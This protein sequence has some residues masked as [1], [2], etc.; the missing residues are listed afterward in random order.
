MNPARKAFNSWKERNGGGTVEDFA[1][2][3]GYSP[4][5]I[6]RL[7][8]GERP[9]PYGRAAKFAEILGWSVGRL[10]TASHKFAEKSPANAKTRRKAS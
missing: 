10:I 3:L 1:R 8:R 6:Y 9:I 2:A 7:M 5:S 4:D